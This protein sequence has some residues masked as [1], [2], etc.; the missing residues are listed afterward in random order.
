MDYAYD[1]EFHSARMHAERAREEAE[2]ERVRPFYLLRPEVFPE[3]NQ[4]CALYGQDIQIGV[5]GFGET[6]DA[7]ARQF[8]IAWLNAKPPKRR[9]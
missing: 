9:A 1:M 7:A 2:H 8:D 6:P 5:A 4:W 3:G